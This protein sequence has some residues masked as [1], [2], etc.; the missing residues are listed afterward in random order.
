MSR[1]IFDPRDPERSGGTFNPPDADDRSRMP[2]DVTDGEVSEEEAQ[3]LEKLAEAN[4]ELKND[5]DVKE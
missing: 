2:E 4:E 1:S 5:P 3:D